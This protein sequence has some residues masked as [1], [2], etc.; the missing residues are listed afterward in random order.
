MRNQTMCS[1]QGGQEGEFCS[2]TTA[3][4][5]LSNITVTAGATPNQRVQPWHWGP[6]KKRH[7]GLA[8]PDGGGRLSPHPLPHGEAVQEPIRPPIHTDVM[9]RCTAVSSPRIHEHDTC[10]YI[11]VI[12]FV[13]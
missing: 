8:Q 13:H 1:R 5:P 4:Y 12:D 10:L 3:D 2:Q 7:A 9:L 11:Y 6:T